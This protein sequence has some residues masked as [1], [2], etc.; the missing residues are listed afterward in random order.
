MTFGGPD[1]LFMKLMKKL[2]RELEMKRSYLCE[3]SV[4]NMFYIILHTQETNQ[5]NRVTECF[6]IISMKIC[7]YFGD[8]I[9]AEKALI[10]YVFIKTQPSI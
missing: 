2:Y 1:L 3:R 4:R 7:L 9:F 10:F 5:H 6:V 8:D